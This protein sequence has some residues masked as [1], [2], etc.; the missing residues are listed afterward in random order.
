VTNPGNVPLSGITV[1]DNV[2]NVT[3]VY[4]SGDANGDSKLD[5]DETWVYSASGTAIAGDYSNI[6]TV[7]GVDANTS[8]TVSDTDD[9]SY[10]GSAPAIEVKKYV[11]DSAGDWQVSWG[12][13]YDITM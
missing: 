8:S 9:S 3:P 2:T 5:T 13:E 11:K 1:T 12:L 6:G 10:F 7:T 4:V